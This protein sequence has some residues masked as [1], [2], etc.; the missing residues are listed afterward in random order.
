MNEKDPVQVFV[1]AGKGQ[2][3]SSISGSLVAAGFSVRIFHAGTDVLQA[4]RDQMPTL[5]IFDV[6]PPH[7]DG[8]DLFRSLS[9]Q[10]VLESTRTIVLSN[11]DAE[12]DKVGALEAGADDYITK[13]FSE[14]ELVARVRAVLRSGR[15]LHQNHVLHVGTISADVDARRVWTEGQEQH[16]TATEF[17]LLV[18]FMHNPGRIV[19]RRELLSRVWPK[20]NDHSRII[21]VHIYNLRKKVETDPSKPVHLITCGKD[22]YMFVGS[23]GHPVEDSK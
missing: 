14:R 2:T 21:S 19:G 17:N 20:E 6:P 3:T 4:A 10:E 22:G 23:N 7:L 1:V 8:D 5:I 11:R 12:E 9:G 18:H 13:P 15:T 16:L